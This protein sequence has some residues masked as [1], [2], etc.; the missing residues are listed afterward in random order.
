[1][2]PP[3]FDGWRADCN[4]HLRALPAPAAAAASQLGLIP[5]Y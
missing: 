3:V 2:G 5:L 1:L 4:S